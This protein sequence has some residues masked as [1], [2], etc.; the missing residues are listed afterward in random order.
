MPTH[1][2]PPLILTSKGHSAN[3]RGCSVVPQKA[4]GALLQLL[5]LALSIAMYA[6]TAGNA[7]T[8]PNIEF[9][10]QTAGLCTLTETK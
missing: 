4:S 5:V 1:V 3:L 6:A 8:G 9:W 10:V 7:D 2:S